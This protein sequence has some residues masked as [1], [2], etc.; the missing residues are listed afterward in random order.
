[1][2]TVAARPNDGQ[3]L[4]N[5]NKALIG[6]DLMTVASIHIHTGNYPPYNIIKFD[7]TH[8]GIEIAISGFTKEEVSI[9][10]DQ[11]QLTVRGEH[12]II[13]E[14]ESINYLHRG[15]ANRNFEQ[16]FTLTEYLTVEDAIIKDGLLKISFLR[17]IPLWRQPHNITIK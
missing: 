15:L 13:P 8:Y 17:I 9:Q 14:N 1:M 7:D 3:T 12:V 16:I 5:L 2:A 4:S 10:I 11:S 6:F